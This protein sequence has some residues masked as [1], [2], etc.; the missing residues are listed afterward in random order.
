MQRREQIHF[1]M[2]KKL[3]PK[4]EP[5]KQKKKSLILFNEH[6]KTY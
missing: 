2:Q 3:K 6:T 5:K 4:R 1:L